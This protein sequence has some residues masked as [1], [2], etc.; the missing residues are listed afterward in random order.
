M[1]QVTPA[2]REVLS[3]A[4]AAFYEENGYIVLENHLGTGVV[5]SI[6]AEIA[7]L[8]AQIRL[9]FDKELRFMKWYGLADGARAA[10][11]PAG[12]G[13]GAAAAASCSRTRRTSSPR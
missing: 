4:Q 12:L 2:Q 6:R 1:D 10:F 3:E 5:E 11:V 7:R 9:S 8:R 13:C